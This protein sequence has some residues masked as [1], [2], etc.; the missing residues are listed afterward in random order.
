SVTK[1]LET[2]RFL[3]FDRTQRTGALIDRA[4]RRQHVRVTDFLELTSIEGIAALVRQRVG[5]AVVPLLRSA[6][7]AQED[8]LRV[9][10]LPGVSEQRSIG[11]LE[12]TR[13]DK[14]GI[15]SA[16]AQQVMAQG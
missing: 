2:E 13:H 12:R 10:P 3:R 16:I 6:T 4:V 14:M 5:I 8:S 1:L 9:I 7:W 15:T 11:L